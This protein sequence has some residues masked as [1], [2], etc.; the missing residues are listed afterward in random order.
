MK[1]LLFTLSL[2]LS[3]TLSAQTIAPGGIYQFKKTIDSTTFSTIGSAGIELIAAPGSNKC[4]I[5]IPGTIRCKRSTGT[6]KWVFATATSI[7]FNIGDV[8]EQIT[9]TSPFPGAANNNISGDNPSQTQSNWT[10]NPNNALTITTNDNSD[11]T[12]GSD[13]ITISFL[14][15]ILNLN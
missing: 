5:I 14:Y 8:V 10:A 4:L 12:S 13:V 3:L 6:N 1:K 2:L 11:P 7:I 15:T 9:F